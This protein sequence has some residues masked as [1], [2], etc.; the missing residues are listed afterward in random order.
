MSIRKDFG[1]SWQTT[2]GDNSELARWGIKSV[3]FKRLLAILDLLRLK[4]LPKNL[5]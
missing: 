5:D 2:Y 4:K 3:I 1:I